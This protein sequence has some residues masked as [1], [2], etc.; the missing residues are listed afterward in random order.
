MLPKYFL[1]LL[2]TCFFSVGASPITLSAQVKS[3]L[4]TTLEYKDTTTLEILYTSIMT[5]D[6][7]TFKN[8][9][10]SFNTDDILYFV[11]SYLP[12]QLQAHTIERELVAFDYLPD[13][14]IIGIAQEHLTQKSDR[15]F[16]FHLKLMECHKALMSLHPLAEETYPTEIDYKKRQEDLAKLALALIFYNNTDDLESFLTIINPQEETV[17]NNIYG[18]L[19][20]LSIALE[21]KDMTEKITTLI[22][23]NIVVKPTFKETLITMHEFLTNLYSHQIDN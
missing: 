2:L 17:K 19:L 4:K 6:N 3:L 15:P 18:Q 22:P 5:G 11:P 13:D 1:A 9:T 21:K 14:M 7:N 20:R 12:L 8:I 16:I 10:Q 23:A